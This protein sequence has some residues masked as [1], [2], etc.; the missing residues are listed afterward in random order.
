MPRHNLICILLVGLV[1]LVCYGRIDRNPYGRY[2]TEVID[3]IENEAL[4]KVSRKELWN[5]AMEGIVARL[6]KGGDQHSDFYPSEKVADFNQELRQEFV[7]VGIRLELYPE[8]KQIIILAPIYGSP[9][10]QAGIKAGDVIVAVDGHR[11]AVDRQRTKKQIMDDVKT[12][13][14]GNAGDSVTLSVLHLGAKEPVD[15]PI[16]RKLVHV[17]T[18]VGDKPGSKG[19]W[20]Y[21][22]PGYGKIAYVRMQHF[23]ETSTTDLKSTIDRLR[24]TGMQALVLDLRG[25]RGGRLDVAIAACDLFLDKGQVIVSTRNRRG[26]KDRP[27][28][29]ASGAGPFTDFP[30][31][32]LVN[33]GSASASEIVAACL[34]DHRRAV[35]V[36]QRSYGKGT[37][38]DVLWIEGGA[39]RLKLTKSSFWRPSGKQI[40]RSWHDGKSAPPEDDWGVIPDDGLLLEIDDLEQYHLN[41]ARHSRD[42]PQAPPLPAEKTKKTIKQPSGEPQDSDPKNDEEPRDS[43]PKNSEKKTPGPTKKNPSDKKS[44]DKKPSDAPA[45]DAPWPQIDRQLILALEYL[46]KQVAK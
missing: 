34:Q 14:E 22:S 25:N 40:H 33:E 43:D 10:D 4:L 12:R 29:L 36:G 11:L 30:M 44:S 5:G 46:Q 32:V 16:V 24:E 9:A 2:F 42:Y 39:S 3:T 31:A 6:H 7:G 18:I 19:T 20:S 23:S 13:I 45:A 17:P 8:L 35:V 37:V 41:R 21:Y 38:Q 26:E 28:S 1:S 15:V 27:D